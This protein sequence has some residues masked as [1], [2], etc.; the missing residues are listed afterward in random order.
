MPVEFDVKMDAKSLSGFVLYHN[1]ARPGGII[2]VIISVA[3]LVAL[4]LRYGAWTGMQKCLLV[5][6]FLLFTVIQPLLLLK[7]TQTQL[8][9]DAFSNPMHYEFKEE[10]FSISQKLSREEFAYS[11]IRKAVIHKNVMYLYM[12]SVSAFIIPRNQCEDIFDTISGKVK[13]VKKS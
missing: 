3:A 2:G 11:D 9:T 5:V 7:K 12:T 13:P 6:L 1:Y 4:I 10:G 8:K